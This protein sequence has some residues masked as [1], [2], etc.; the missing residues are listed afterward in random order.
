VQRATKLGGVSSLKTAY[1]NNKTYFSHVFG[2][3][4]VNSSMTILPASSPCIEIS[5]N[6]LGRDVEEAMTFVWRDREPMT[7]AVSFG[8]G[9]EWLEWLPC[10]VQLTKI[11]TNKIPGHFSNPS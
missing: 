11:G 8:G 5:R 1:K 6:T 3:L 9:D 10:L 2:A 4:S 7:S